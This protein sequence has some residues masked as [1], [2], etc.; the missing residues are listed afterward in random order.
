MA[1]KG[2]SKPYYAKYTNNAGVVSYSDGGVFGKAVAWGVTVTKSDDNHLYADNNIAETDKGKF[3][4]GELS[5]TTSGI[6]PDTSKLILGIKSKTVTVNGKSVTAYVFDDD[7]ESP[8][9]G[10]GIIEWHQNNN[11]DKYRAVILLRTYFNIP[12]D[13]ATTKGERVEWGTPAITA[14]IMR[15]E[16][17]DENGNHPW[18][19]EA[20]F[21]TEADAELYIKE[22]L[23]IVAKSAPVT[24]SVASGTYTTAQNVT[25]STTEAAGAIYYT[26]DGTIPSATNGTPYENAIVLAK[27]SNTCIKAIC[28]TAGKSDSDILELYITVTDE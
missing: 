3:Q 25:L 16:A 22:V 9:L 23:G 27:P 4:S 10:F 6:A 14:S 12:E 15:S 5:V 8:D 19:E 7:A 24:S 28:I 2:L 26:D 13:A 17:V 11:T 1:I 20:W 18:K 21:D